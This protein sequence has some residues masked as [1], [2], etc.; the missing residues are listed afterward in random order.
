MGGEEPALV[1]TASAAKKGGG[2]GDARL[3]EE[4]LVARGRVDADVGVA[5]DLGRLAS[6]VVDELR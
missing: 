4:L 2:Y 1:N 5:G 3:I 6:A